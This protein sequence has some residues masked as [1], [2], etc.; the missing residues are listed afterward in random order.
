MNRKVFHAREFENYLV[1]HQG[2]RDAKWLSELEPAGAGEISPA[3]DKLLD[4]VPEDANCIEVCRTLHRLPDVVGWLALFEE[5]LHGEI[6]AYLEKAQTILDDSADLEQ[7]MAKVKSIPFPLL[8]YSLNR[9]GE[10]GKLYCLLPP[11]IPFPRAKAM[12][13]LQKLLADYAEKSDEVGGTLV[14]TRVQPETFECSVS[15]NTD[16]LSTLIRTMG[17]SWVDTY[18][19]GPQ[20]GMNLWRD[21]GNPRD[22]EARVYDEVLLVNPRW[23]QIP[24]PKPKTQARASTPVPERDSATPSECLDLSSVY[25]ASLKDSWHG[26]SVANNTLRNLPDGI[27]EFGDVWFDVRGIVQ[28][29][30][31]GLQA[32]GGIKYPKCVDG[33][34][35]DRPAVKLHILHAAGWQAPPETRIGCYKVRYANGATREIPIVYGKDVKDWWHQIDP[36]SAEVAW[37][38]QSTASSDIQVA[39]YKTTWENPLPDVKIQS[40]DYCSAMT[41]SAPFL[42]AITAE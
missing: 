2:S 38:G 34:Q 19:A 14:Y 1:F 17:N 32:Q 8:V 16:A 40:I 29:S 39:L 41:D 15:Q 13:I 23:A 30:G 33:I 7:G 5:K 37:S 6:D 28:V 3:I 9:D 27:Q 4:R 10:T 26:T 25:N 21:L 22:G 11:N 18:G 36:G 24:G 31:L 20:S 42:I 12:P 35:V